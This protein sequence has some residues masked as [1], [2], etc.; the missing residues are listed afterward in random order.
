MK[1]FKNELTGEIFTEIE[2]EKY[3]GSEKFEEV[4]PNTTE[5]A[6]EKHIPVIEVNGNSVTVTVGEVIHPMTAEHYIQ[7]ISLETEKSYQKKDL[8][9]EDSPIATFT[10]SDNDKVLRAYEHCNLHGLWATK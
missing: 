10:I 6:L 9:P 8:T 3:T 1:F 2:K 5:A 4:V 7:W